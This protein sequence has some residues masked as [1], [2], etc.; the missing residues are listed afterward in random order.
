M[1]F[2]AQCSALC[3]CYYTSPSVFVLWMADS[4]LTREPP[5]AAA[6]RGLSGKAPVLRSGLDQHLLIVS[7]SATNEQW[8]AKSY[9]NSKKGSASKGHICS[10][11]WSF[12]HRSIF[13]FCLCKT[14]FSLL[15]TWG[16]H[17]WQFLFWLP[18]APCSIFWGRH[19]SCL[20][21]L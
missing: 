17:I 1:H 11:W 12:V 14:I 4:A 19:P 21:F 18:A 2:W 16:W 10:S 6:H 7:S 9:S 5:P 20:E 8:D 15:S 13:Y 3:A